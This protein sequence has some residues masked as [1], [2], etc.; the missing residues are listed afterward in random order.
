MDGFKQEIEKMV[1]GHISDY[2]YFSVIRDL[3]GEFGIPIE[4]AKEMKEYWL[5][6]DEN[7]LSETSKSVL[8]KCAPCFI[9]FV[10]IDDTETE[11]E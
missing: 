11:G 8:R 6:K 9:P 7:S 2:D 10:K 5:T 1:G 4:S 3:S